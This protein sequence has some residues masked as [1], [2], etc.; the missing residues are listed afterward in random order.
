MPANRTSSLY[1]SVVKAMLS[2]FRVKFRTGY[3]DSSPYTL[4][5]GVYAVV[6]AIM[7]VRLAADAPTAS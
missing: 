1:I 4:M 3:V 6:L 7:T 5:M 2:P